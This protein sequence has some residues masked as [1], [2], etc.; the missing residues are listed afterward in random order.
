MISAK[1]DQR[2]HCQPLQC[3]DHYVSSHH[4]NFGIA[5]SEKSK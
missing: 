4:V 1:E 2:W 3:I 5:E